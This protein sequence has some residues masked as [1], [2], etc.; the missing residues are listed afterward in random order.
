M[1]AKAMCRDLRIAGLEAGPG[2]LVIHLGHDS[3]VDPDR[4]LEIVHEGRG[5]V[6]LTD[7][8]K[9]VVRAGAGQ[10]AGAK[11]AIRFLRRLGACEIKTA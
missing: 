4:V 11:G 9:I 3:V 5:A 8:L 10:P 7:D 2:R 6:R 1:V